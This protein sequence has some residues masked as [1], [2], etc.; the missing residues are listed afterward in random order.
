MSYFLLP[1]RRMLNRTFWVCFLMIPFIAGAQNDSTHNE[2]IKVKTVI[3]YTLE[4]DFIYGNV[5]VHPLDTTVSGVDKTNPPLDNQYNFLGTNG[6]AAND[7]IYSP[8]YSLYTVTGIKSYDLYFISPDDIFYHRTNKRFTEVNY[9]TGAFKES[10]ISVLHTQNITKTWNAGIYFERMSVKDFMFNS[11]TYRSKFRFSTSYHSPDGRY[12]VFAGGIWNTINNDVNGGLTSDSLFENTPVTNLGIKGLA[13]PIANASENVRRK[14][15]FANQFYDLGKAVRDTAGEIIGRNTY[16]RMQYRVSYE[17]KSFA[18]ADPDP[19]SLFY[20]NFYYGPETYDSLYSN[21]IINRFA[22]QKPAGAFG[23]SGFM[24]N[25]SQGVFVELQNIKYGQ[26]SDSSWHNLSGGA[27]ILWKKD[28]VSPSVFAEASYVFDGMDEKN[29]RFN[30]ILTSKQYS[31]GQLSFELKA[32]QA[33]PDLLFRWYDG[34]N[35][36]WKND[37]EKISYGNLTAAY[38]LSKYRFRVSYSHYRILNYVYLN[39]AS[40]PLQ[41]TQSVNIDQLSVRKDF[42]FR[43][44]HLDNLFI[45]Q[46]SVNIVIQLPDFISQNSLYYEKDFFGGS[47]RLS[48]GFRFAFCSKYYANEFMPALGEFYLQT[49]KE[50][51]GYF[52]TDLFVDAKIKTAVIFLKME[53]I[54]DGLNGQSYFTTPHYPMPGRVFTFGLRWRFFD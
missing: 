22:L 51:N 10:G 6:S 16:L 27:N 18:Y 2:T 32:G 44:F 34:N 14:T 1:S 45:F 50:T 8:E 21:E 5:P 37:F 29:Y 49:E 39:S 9:H 35:F 11:D 53:N 19:D 15:F 40:F 20:T 42:T 13:S 12:T 47:L 17:H 36:I 23:K 7:Q 24:R 4:K 46:N 33:S 28:S 48:T 38:S 52:R 41:F 54:A 25:W 31:F 43:N 30:G 26:R 3:N